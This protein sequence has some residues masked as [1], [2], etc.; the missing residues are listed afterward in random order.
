MCMSILNNITPCVPQ[1]ILGISRSA[2]LVKLRVD[3][4]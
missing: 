3:Y 4:E 2:L 1:I